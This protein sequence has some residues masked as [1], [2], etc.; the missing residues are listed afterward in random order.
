MTFSHG[1]IMFILE[2]YYRN[3]DVLSSVLYQ[4]ISFGVLFLAVLGFNLRASY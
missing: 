3:E 2:K 4:I 1:H